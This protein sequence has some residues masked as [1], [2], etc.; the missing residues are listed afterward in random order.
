[1]CVKWTLFLDLSLEMCSLAD[2]VEVARIPHSVFIFCCFVS[3]EV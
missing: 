3:L 1:M 2:G